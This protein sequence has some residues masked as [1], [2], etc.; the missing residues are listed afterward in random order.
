MLSPE[1]KD[2][3]ITRL[4]FKF[5]VILPRKKATVSVL[6]QLPVEGVIDVRSLSFFGCRIIPAAPKLSFL[7]ANSFA[8][9][10]P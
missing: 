8:G 1:T 2:W 3:T 6:V 4:N 5:E 9:K 7:K 10:K